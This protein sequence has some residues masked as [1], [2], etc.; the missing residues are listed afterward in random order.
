MIDP[1]NKKLS[2]L[3]QSRL[4]RLS[5]S[6]IYYKPRPIKPQDLELM[7]K[8]PGRCRAQAYDL[9]INGSEAGGG[10]IRIHDRDIQQKAFNLL[11]IDAETAMQRFGFLLEALQ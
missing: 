6:S 2:L 5:R 3:R 10:T 8:E 1:H 4:L 7:E 9:V 11:G